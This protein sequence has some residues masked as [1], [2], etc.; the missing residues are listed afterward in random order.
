MNLSPGLTEILILLFF[1]IPLLVALW[2]FWL[3]WTR[4]R[5]PETSAISVQYDPPDDLTPGECAALVENKVAMS[6]IIATIV[7]LSVKGFLTIKQ[8]GD[9]GPE[10][11]ASGRIFVFRL[12]KEQSDWKS[13]MPHEQAVLTGM[14]NRM[15]PFQVLS[16]QMSKLQT[17]ALDS[18][19]APLYAQVHDQIAAM[20]ANIAADPGLHAVADRDFGPRTAVALSDL[21]NQFYMHL[22][23]IR[24]AIF[25]SIVAGGYY[26]QRPDRIR[27][28]YGAGGIV[29][30]LVMAFAGAILSA[31]T[32]TPAW[33]WILAGIL[34]GAIILVGGRMLTPRTDAGSRALAKVMGFRDFLGRVE[35]DPIQ[36]VEK[37]PDLFE[38]YLPYAMAL[39]VESKWSQA[40]GNLSVPAPQWYWSNRSENFQPAH[41]VD[42][43]GGMSD[44][45]QT[46]LTSKPARLA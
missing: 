16:E 34:T 25:D 32:R 5:D 17:R 37:S 7:D 20:E 26:G 18:P 23:R 45:A 12:L 21:H 4:G 36:R 9:S 2:M 39:R 29:V 31:A 35:K 24:D 42:D 15:D 13:L 33:P 46:V 41:L 43:L 30:G 10:A 11:A 28:I 19:V 8:E 1:A 38:K 44:Q 3:C 27:L 40:F 6:T 14:F 22:Q